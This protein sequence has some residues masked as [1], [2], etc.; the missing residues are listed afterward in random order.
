MY[1]ILSPGARLTNGFIPQFKCAP[2]YI[3]MLGD[4]ITLDIPFAPQCIK[5]EPMVSKGLRGRP[6]RLF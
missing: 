2:D 1:E 3:S 5:R 4:S 6:V